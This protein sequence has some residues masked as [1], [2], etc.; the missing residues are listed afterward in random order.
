MI[1]L[2]IDALFRAEPEAV[3]DW[4]TRALGA[5]RGARAP[6]NRGG[7]RDARARSRGRRQ[8][9]RGSGRLRRGDCLVAAMSDEELTA[10]VD[11]AAYLCSAATF[12]DRY[13]DA[14][15]HAERALR[16]GRAAGH[17]HPTLIPALGAAHF[18]RGRLSEA[19]EVL[20]AGV[21]AAR[22]RASPRAWRGCCATAHSCSCWRAT[23]G[24]ARAGRRGA[25][26]HATAR[27][28]RPVG[29]GGDGGRAGVGDGRAQPTRRRRPGGLRDDEPLR[30]IP[31]RGGRWASRAS[32]RPMRTSITATRRRGRRRRPKRTRPP[33]GSRWPPPGR[34]AP[35]RQS[36]FTQGEPAAAAKRAL[37]SAAAAEQV[38][39]VIEAALSRTV[40]GRA[41][42]AAGEQDRAAAEIE[43]AAATFEACGALPHRD[44]AE[45]E[46]RRLGRTVHRRTP[47]GSADGVGVETLTQREHQV[48]ALVVDRKTNPEIAAELFLSLKTVETHLRNIFRKLDVSSRV[49]LARTVER[50]R[51]AA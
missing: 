41:L 30:R 36:R 20:D 44:A 15:A 39:A 51:R 6:A 19:A 9:R 28:E 17:L 50:A 29:M 43:R 33:W 11:A 8:H 12:L 48:A 7:R 47:K 38:G 4:A 18:L 49:E 3:R 37:A 46:L 5:A 25:R 32:R 42:A 22:W 21:E 31:A 10:R 16:L 13:D 14:V 27:R 1:E 23:P 2:A 40:A 26:A 24:G 35:R 45:Q 34:S